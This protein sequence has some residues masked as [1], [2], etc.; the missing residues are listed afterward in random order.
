MQ[1]WQSELRSITLYLNKR[2]N[3]KS[4]CCM[5]TKV[6]DRLFV[7]LVSMTPEFPSLLEDVT[8]WIETRG[9][10]TSVMTPIYLTVKMLT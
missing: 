7:T 9:S 4:T 10:T 8:G 1:E 6:T 5:K 2:S 3:W